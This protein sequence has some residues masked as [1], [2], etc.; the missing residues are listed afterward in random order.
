MTKAYQ[1]DA[2]GY[3]AGESE[4]YGL[5]PNNATYIAPAKKDGCIPRWTG[6]KWEQV[7]NH[8]GES[9]YVDGK[10]FT[11]TEY[12]PYPDGWSV[13]PPPPTLEET[14]AGTVQAVNGS[15]EAACAALLGDEP[16]SAT[17]TYSIQQAE[18]EAWT[19]DPAAP[20]PML[21]MLAATRRMNKAELVRRV[22]AKAALYKQASGLLLGQQQALMDDVVAIMDEPDLPDD[23]K[24]VALEN[25]DVAIGLP[26]APEPPA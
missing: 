1:Y 17:A 14:R 10:P 16:P 20:T 6:K 7:E 26:T 19:A 22:L 2:S 3:F 5:L 25:L 23:L 21:D 4:D 24:I 18:A 15:F 11:V 13:D 9:G 8:K 12:G